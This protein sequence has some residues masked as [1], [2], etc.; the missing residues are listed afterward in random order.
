MKARSLIIAVLCSFMGVV[1][2]FAQNLF[3]ENTS[4]SLTGVWQM[5]FYSSS[6][7]ALPGDLKP[8]NSLKILGE[9]GEFTNVVMMPSGAIIIGSG[10]YTQDNDSTFT[11]HVKKNIHLPQLNGKDNVMH[12]E[13]AEN[14]TLMFVRFRATEDG[15]T[16]VWSHEIWRKIDM[17]SSYPTDIVR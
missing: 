13:M 1:N 3:N 7:P 10:T 16:D 15:N 8:S 14:G 9:G 4:A 5:C 6:L 12:Y 2:T 17:P 11:E